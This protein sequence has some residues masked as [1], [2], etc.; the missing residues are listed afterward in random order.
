[1]GANFEKV[2]EN[3]K[4][5]KEYTLNKKTYLSISGCVMTTNWKDI[6]DL[7]HFANKNNI[8]IHFNIVWNPG[9]LSLRYL[10]YSELEEIAVF[11]KK[12]LFD[13]HNSIQKENLKN[14]S[15]LKGTIALWQNERNFTTV[16]QERK[17]REFNSIFLV[18]KVENQFE[19]EIFVACLLHYLKTCNSS[20][21][22][23]VPEKIANISPLENPARIKQLLNKIYSEQGDVAFV[24]H[25]YPVL[26]L[27]YRFFYGNDYVEEFTKRVFLFRDFVISN[28]NLQALV[29]DI[30]DD[31]EKYSIVNQL[32]FMKEK[33]L[34]EMK[35]L[36]EELY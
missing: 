23:E 2:M 5:F 35:R 36:I 7:I 25:Y 31:I 22:L 18:D 9:H 28:K 24:N 13:S 26:P 19:K 27:F 34:D 14:F 33:K 10:H 4:Y 6:P 20:L 11:Y 29:S 21:L 17:A 16:L 15:E 12:Q 1:V 30:I 3:L 32:D 8:Y